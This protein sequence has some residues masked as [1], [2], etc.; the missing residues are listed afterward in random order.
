MK[1]EER[2]KRVAEFFRKEQ[3]RLVAYTRKLMDSSEDLE[4]EDIVQD[5][6]EGVFGLADIT[7]PI[8]NLGAYVYQSVRNRVIDFFRRRKKTVSLDEQTGDNRTPFLDRLRDER[9]E[10]DTIIE[11]RDLARR[12]ADVFDRLN[13]REKAVVMATEI[14][15]R[16]FE[17][18]SRDWGEPVGTLLSR[19]S[20]A[21]A[22]MEKLLSTEKTRKGG[23]S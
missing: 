20:R 17:E 19:K 15:G 7:R 5:V 6:M 3:P 18:L 4:P 13:D 2:N 14:E 16:P 12:L 10:T 22:K 11:R 23:L 8:E 1:A 21:L 9:L